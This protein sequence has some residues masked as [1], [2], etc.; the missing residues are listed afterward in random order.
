MLRGEGSLRESL[1]RRRELLEGV[2]KSVRDPLRLSHA[3]KVSA[4]QM[5][6]MVREHKLEGVVAK[7]QSQGGI[8]DM[9]SFGDFNPSF[10]FI[11]RNP[12]PRQ[13]LSVLRIP[14]ERG[15]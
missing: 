2:M 3:F 11:G 1:A 15:Q 13:V 7:R 4:A 9:S 6:A 14:R 10:L 12:A 5:I 8:L